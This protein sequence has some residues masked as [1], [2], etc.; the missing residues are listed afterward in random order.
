MTRQEAIDKVFGMIGTAEQHEALEFLVPEV[1][2][3]RESYDKQQ[4]DK[5]MLR[6]IKRY[7]KEQGD[8]PT[9]L[10]NGTVA[11]SDMIDWLEKQE[12]QKEQKDNKFA[13]RVLPCSAAW[14]E[15]DDEK[16]KEQKPEEKPINWTELTWE[17]INYLEDLMA[18]VHYEFRNGIG[19]ESFGKEVLEKFREYKGDEYL[20]EIEQKPAEWSEEDEKIW[21]H[22][23]DCA[24]SRAWIPFNEISWLAAHKPQ[25]YWKPSKEQMEA[26]HR[27]IYYLHGEG[28]E[29]SD[30]QS[31]YEELR[32]LGVKE[33]PEYYQ[34][35]DPDC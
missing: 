7:I 12:E 31:L 13:P 9:G 18:K 19:A 21:N 33:E 3:L 2:E 29:Y 15:D 28:Y 1:R 27:S 26:L 11:V 22:I 8:K 35:F 25:F 24:E 30:I 14:F 4:E 16:Q 20:D 6:E 23:I 10:P 32:K 17:D 5:R 34:H